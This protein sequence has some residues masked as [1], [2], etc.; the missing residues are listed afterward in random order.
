M[1]KK[2][3][4]F[5]MKIILVPI[6]AAQAFLF[7]A[8]LKD[9]E[10]TAPIEITRPV[11]HSIQPAAGALN[12]NVQSPIRVVF[13]EKMNVGTFVNRLK[14]RDYDGNVIETDIS[15]IDTVVYFTPKTALKSATIYYAELRG[16][17]RDADNNS[18]GINGEGVFD[19]TTLLTSTWFYTGGDYSANGFYPI[20][21]RDRKSGS[22][23]IINYVDSVVTTSTGLSVP[24]GMAISSD[25]SYLIVSNT[26]KNQIL[27]INSATGV[28][29]TTIPVAAHPSEVIVK[30]D[31]AYVVCVDSKSLC[32]INVAS[33][34]LDA[35]FPLTIY[36][37]KAAISSDGTILYTLDQVTRALYLINTSN[38]ATI[39]SISSAVAKLVTGELVYDNATDKLYI[40]DTKGYKLTI[41]DKDGSSNLAAIT[42]AGNKEPVDVYLTDK[43]IY[44]A[45]GNAVYKY[46]KTSQ[47]LLNKVEF[48][49]NVKSLTIIPSGELL[50][51]TLA[52]SMAIVD[53]NTLTILKDKDLASSGIETIVSGASKR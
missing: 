9:R 31:Y 37:G 40:C 10:P 48:G 41:L 22:I 24:E 8:C 33:K 25:G 5:I 39:K 18:I 51:V 13:N 16:R 1:K 34:N 38:G 12:Y 43:F 47:A 50:Y 30:G 15:Q 20:Y 28:I 32:K 26:G 3:K 35:T 44:A 21:I 23:R 6:M 49:T 27:F 4:L 45:A 29:E 36:P 19:D 42:F 7:T 14:L 11:Y 17:I 53:I 46:D 2:N 52:T